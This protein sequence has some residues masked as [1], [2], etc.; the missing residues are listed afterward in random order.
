MP[1]ANRLYTP[2]GVWHITHRC[3]NREFLLKFERDRKRWKYWLFQARK[4]FGL[5]VLNYIVTSN[6]I[7]LLVRDTTPGT[8]ARS[9]HLI[10][11]RVGQ[12][13]NRRKSRTGAFWEDRYFATAVSTDRHLFQCLVY[14]DLNMVRAGV[15]SHPS[16]WSV[17][18][19]NDIQKPPLRYRII[20]H[21]AICA[22]GGF[23]DFSAFRRGHQTWVT[24]AL[25]D[26]NQLRESKWTEAVAVGPDSF[27]SKFQGQ[28]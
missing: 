11:G 13:Y 15:V 28:H 22:L 18:G 27:T 26:D 8:I 2:G 24:D 5:S 6:H 4:R 14:I 17:C 20:D 12:E 25:D 16:E 1:R 9:L 10:A 3:H 19:Y 23:G 21:D 7:H